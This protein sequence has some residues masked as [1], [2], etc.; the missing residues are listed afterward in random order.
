VAER[1]RELSSLLDISRNVTA[2]LDLETLFSLILDQMKTLIDYSGATIFSIQGHEFR[3]LDYR[4]PIARDQ[5]AQLRF[6]IEDAIVNQEVMR[7]RTPV[8]I[9]DVR[10]DTPLAR[11][12]QDI[13]G[14]RMRTA[15]GY[16]RSWLGVPLLVQDHIIGM[17]T[18][19]HDQPG[20]YTPRHAD[21]AL[22]IANQAAIAIENARLFEQAQTLA[23]M[24]ERQRLA[25]E[26]HDSV[27]QALYG[28]ALGARTARALL[29][30]DP[31]AAIEPI[32]YV[33]AL[34]NAG[35]AE[36]RA[37]IFELRPESL[38]EEGLVVALTKHAESLRARHQLDV[39]IE[40]G[41]EPDLPLAMK[42]ELYRIAQ[43]SLHNIVKHARASAVTL[44]LYAPTPQ[45]PVLAL[46]ISDN[47][48]GFDSEGA[49]P[50]HLG[51]RSMRERAARLGG[52]LGIDSAPGRGTHIRVRV[53]VRQDDA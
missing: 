28:I 46:D 13:S 14:G 7:R 16:I 27:S 50:G 29:D 37:L 39:Q 21:L 18:L 22:T 2:T 45:A 30:R 11:A 48:L 8:I 32:E 38:E 44:R 51:L 3:I 34:A 42:E 5:L 36:M 26:L 33:A 17:L 47:G 12:F 15:F 19:D 31:V 53:P 23:V 24:I 49:F 43:E 35:M 6:P 52:T 4:G 10:A 1:T 25:R 9:D 41:E 20:H 40:L